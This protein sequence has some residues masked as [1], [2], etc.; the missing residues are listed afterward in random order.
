VSKY[1]QS[2]ISQGEHAQLDFKFSVNDS[3]KIARSI[4]AFSNANGGKLLIGVKDNGKI[5]GINTDE[6]YYMIESAAQLYCKPPVEFIANT[7]VVWGKTVLEISIAPGK[8]RPYQA[9]DETGKYQTYVRI[10]DENIVADKVQELAW[11]IESE[12]RPVSFHL[13][14]KETILL[15]Y[16]KQNP[17]ISVKKLAIIGMLTETD[18]EMLLAYFLT[19]KLITPLHTEKGFVYALSDENA[20][21]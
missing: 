12:N 3:K 4:A 15:N 18:A 7:H 17:H 5:A 10:A 13:S 8:L 6:E 16:L 9:P 14:E 11:Q 2:L 1:L 20:K 21:G 19:I